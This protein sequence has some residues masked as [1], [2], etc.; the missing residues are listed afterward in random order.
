MAGSEQMRLET[1]TRMDAVQGRT[2]YGWSVSWP[3][4]GVLAWGQEDTPPAAAEA[5][6]G[7]LRLLE[8]AG[9]GAV[10]KALW[11]MDRGV[12]YEGSNLAEGAWLRWLREWVDRQA[13]EGVEWKDADVPMGPGGGCARRPFAVFVVPR[14]E[15]LQAGEVLARCWRDGGG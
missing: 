8:A 6:R 2:V 4:R 9:P 12:G 13:P 5:A 3:G 14:A 15:A 11:Y 10:G 7:A 1:R